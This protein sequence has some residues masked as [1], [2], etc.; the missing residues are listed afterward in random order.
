MCCA[1]VSNQ[2]YSASWN[3]RPRAVRRSKNQWYSA[4]WNSRP[5]AVRRSKNQ[6]YSASWYSRPRTV[7]RSQ[8]KSIRLLGTA[9]PVL[10][11]DLKTKGT[12]FP[13]H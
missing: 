10:C 8:T 3:S 9:D 5:R 11:V 2:R 7:H 13:S 4:S 12:R 1:S 6:W